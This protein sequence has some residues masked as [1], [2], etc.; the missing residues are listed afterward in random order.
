MKHVWQTNKMPDPLKCRV[1]DPAYIKANGIPG[2]EV[3]YLGVINKI[4]TEP[5]HEW[6]GSWNEVKNPDATPT[7][8]FRPISEY[9]FRVSQE[10]FNYKRE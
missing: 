1:G 7:I 5:I 9:D 4:V 3:F 2:Q 10:D 8:Y 6:P